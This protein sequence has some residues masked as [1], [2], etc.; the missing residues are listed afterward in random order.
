M[1]TGQGL[2]IR[3]KSTPQASPIR[4][5][6]ILEPQGQ[7]QYLKYLSIT[8]KGLALCAPVFVGKIPMFSGT[9]GALSEQP[10]R[11]PNKNPTPMYGSLPK[12]QPIPSPE[13]AP[14]AGNTYLTLQNRT[15]Y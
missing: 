5:S 15:F 14:M 11:S 10:A 8:A 4:T 3:H 9:Q 2:H 12:G 6:V 7:S 1:P 13:Q